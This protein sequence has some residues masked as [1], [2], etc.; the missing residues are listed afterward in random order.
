MDALTSACAIDLRNP[1]NMADT[2]VLRREAMRF[3]SLIRDGSMLNVNLVVA[4]AAPIYVYS[5][6]LY[7]Y[8]SPARSR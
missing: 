3:A 8:C 5:T 4:M 7:T 1:V 2:L 6:F